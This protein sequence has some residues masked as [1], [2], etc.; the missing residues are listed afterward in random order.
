MALDDFVDSDNWFLNRDDVPE[1][2]LNE[3]KFPLTVYRA[4][5]L[6]NGMVDLKTEGVGIYWTY[7]PRVAE[8]WMFPTRPVW[9]LR[10]TAE[11]DQVDW[12]KT[13]DLNTKFEVEREIRLLAGARLRINAYKRRHSTS[14]LTFSEDWEHDG[15]EA[16]A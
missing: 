6:T 12:G 15:L 2:T 3:L 5:K 7:S 16:I 4:V 13:R 8:H 11:Y 9:I 14:F 10:A 1:P